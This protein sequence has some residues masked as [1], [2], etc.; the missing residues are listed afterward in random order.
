MTNSVNLYSEESCLMRCDTLLLGKYF[1]WS[2]ESQCLHLRDSAV[3]TQ[4]DLV[5]YVGHVWRKARLCHE[6]PVI[7]MLDILNTFKKS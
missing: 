5:Y 6:M 4:K 2:E 1:R 7:S 3:Q